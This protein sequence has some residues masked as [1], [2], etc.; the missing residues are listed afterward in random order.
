MSGKDGTQKALR[1][2]WA[3]IGANG[4]SL[5]GELLAASEV[6][7]RIELRRQGITPTRV[8]RSRRRA[9]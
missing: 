6:R 2:Q 7:A 1:F 8:D 4:V 3:G 5:S 9:T